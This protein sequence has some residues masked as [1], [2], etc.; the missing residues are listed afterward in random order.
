[1]REEDDLPVTH[2]IEIVCNDN[3][4]SDDA[5]IHL[6][7]QSTGLSVTLIPSTINANLTITPG[8]TKPRLVSEEHFLPVW[9]SNSGFVPIGD[10]VVCD[11][12]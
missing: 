8:E 1:M 5:V 6:P 4:L 12:W 2:S 9:S 3:K 11:V 7:L 10:V